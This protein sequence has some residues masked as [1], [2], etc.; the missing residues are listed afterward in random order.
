MMEQF[1]ET[2]PIDMRVWLDDQKPK[3]IDDMARLS[4]Q[5]V[6]LRKPV[7]PVLPKSLSSHNDFF[8]TVALSKPVNSTTTRPFHKVDNR[9]QSN[10]FFSGKSSSPKRFERFPSSTVRC[11]YCKMTDHTISECRKRKQR[12]KDFSET[13][14]KSTNA[15]ST[16]NLILSTH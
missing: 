15:N 11:A 9:K 4:D 8:S 1:L 5:D 10:S 14:V 2:V 16:V 13:H 7:D 12:E 3:T 6:A